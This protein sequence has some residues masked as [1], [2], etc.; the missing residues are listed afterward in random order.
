[1]NDRQPS[2]GSPHLLVTCGVLGARTVWAHRGQGGNR[3]CCGR[4]G[5]RQTPGREVTSFHTL[6][7]LLPSLAQEGLNP[8][9]ATFHQA[10]ARSTPA[11]ERESGLLLPHC[12]F[13]QVTDEE[14][15]PHSQRQAPG[16][17]TPVPLPPH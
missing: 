2:T 3:I 4:P 17:A 1:M 15:E 8:E 5:T 9:R 13:L 10:P 6:S 14:T 16:A 12:R 7:S 11:R